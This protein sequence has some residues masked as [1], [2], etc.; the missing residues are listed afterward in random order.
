[1]IDME[2]DLQSSHSN[3]EKK[4]QSSRNGRIFRSLS[5]QFYR[6]RVRAYSKKVPFC[7]CFLNI[8]TQSEQIDNQLELFNL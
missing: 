4:A 6:F 7:R 2:I 5:T 1:M 8:T 3:Q